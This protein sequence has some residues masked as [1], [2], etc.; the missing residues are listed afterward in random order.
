MHTQQPEEVGL[1]DKTIGRNF[2]ITTT[3]SGSFQPIDATPN[4]NC[5][6]CWWHRILSG[7]RTTTAT[8]RF[9]SNNIHHPNLRIP[10]RK[11]VGLDRDRWHGVSIGD[12]FGDSFD[13]D[14]LTKEGTTT[15][16]TTT[17]ETTKPIS[18]SL[19]LA[20]GCSNIAKAPSK[21][22]NDDRSSCST[23]QTIIEMSRNQYHDYRSFDP[24]G[25]PTIGMEVFHLS[26]PRVWQFRQWEL[27]FFDSCFDT[28]WICKEEGFASETLLNI[29]NKRPNMLLYTTTI[30]VSLVLYYYI[31]PS[32]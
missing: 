17:T 1:P 22:W 30:L 20:I 19:G 18:R 5:S 26:R 14:L 4:A 9:R 25:V 10:R 2:I 11:G 8:F 3:T 32:S 28:L 6:R 31:H 15:T 12:S 16:A 27:G 21:I 23:M 29:V 13:F 7:A 24:S